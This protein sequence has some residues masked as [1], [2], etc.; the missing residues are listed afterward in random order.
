MCTENCYPGIKEGETSSQQLLQESLILSSL[1]NWGLWDFFSPWH[2]MFRSSK[3]KARSGW[4]LNH[5]FSF[6]H[7]LGEFWF[8][9]ANFFPRKKS[10]TL[11]KV[12]SFLNAVL[13]TWVVS[14]SKMIFFLCCTSFWRAWFASQLFFTF[15]YL[16]VFSSK[17]F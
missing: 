11:A 7:L 3:S 14:L 12:R 5:K 9:K 16:S 10:T 1:L 17:H 4:Y 8:P 13:N 2:A 6:C 15:A